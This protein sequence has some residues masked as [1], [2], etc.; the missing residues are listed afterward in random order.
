M[1]CGVLHSSPEGPALLSPGPWDQDCIRSLLLEM[2]VLRPASSLE[3]TKESESAQAAPNETRLAGAP[4]MPGDLLR[5]PV[6]RDE[7]RQHASH[8][9]QN[10]INLLGE[11]LLQISGERT[12]LSPSFFSQE[13]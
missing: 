6:S 1:Q 8:S 3:R 12:F 7:R 2:T 13:S 4:T 5:E 11:K 9:E 10:Y